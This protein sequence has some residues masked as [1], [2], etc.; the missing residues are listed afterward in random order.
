MYLFI[1][2]KNTEFS[3]LTLLVVT[4]S[5][6]EDVTLEFVTEGVT[7]DLRTIS[8]ISYSILVLLNETF[9]CVNVWTSYN[10]QAKA[11]LTPPLSP[12]HTNTDT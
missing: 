11:V 12:T 2:P 1:Q 10:S 6:L 7:G 9:A 8:P 3:I 5:D 4:T